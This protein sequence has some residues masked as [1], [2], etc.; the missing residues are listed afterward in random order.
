K[1]AFGGLLHRR[2]HYTHSVIHETLVDLLAIQ[3]EIH[4]GI[5]AVMDGT[6]AGCGPGPRTMTPVIT[7]YILA[8]SDSVAIDAVAAKIMGFDPMT[9]DYIRIAHEAGL[10]VGRPEEIQIEGE[11]ISGVNLGFHVG[12]N[13]VSRFGRSVWF[14]PLHFMQNLLFRTWLVYFFVFGSAFYHD[15]LWYPLVGRRRARRWMRETEWGRLFQNQ[16]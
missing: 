16:D 15:S 5:F 10:G 7:D 14:G 12:N 4:R 2:R 8:S 11:D 9:I 1:N 6:T 3:K 13:V